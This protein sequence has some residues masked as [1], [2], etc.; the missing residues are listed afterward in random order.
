MPTVVI[1]IAVFGVNWGLRETKGYS[2][3]AASD[4][5]LAMLIFDGGMI[6]ASEAVHP[7]INN[8]ELRT[9]VIAWHLLMGIVTAFVWYFL[10]LKWGEPAVAE[11]YK[12]RGRRRGASPSGQRFPIGVFAVCWMVV[13]ALISARVSF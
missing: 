3:T 11:Y 7:F 5:A 8:P 1:P 4:F 6:S 9:I 10:L 12:K 2:Q 13:F